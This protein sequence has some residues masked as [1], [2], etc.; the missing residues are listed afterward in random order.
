M[1]SR[2]KRSSWLLV[3]FV[4]GF[5][6][7][8]FFSRAIY[9]ALLPEVKVSKVTAGSV[10]LEQE[11]KEYTVASEDECRI[12]MP[13]EFMEN[14]I[15]IEEIPL[16]SGDSFKT[17]D[18]LICL[19]AYQG[20][21]LLDNAKKNLEK[22]ERAKTEW[23]NNYESQM[24]KL[25]AQL[26]DLE[27]K[28][29]FDEAFSVKSELS[30]MKSQKVYDDVYL[31]DLESTCE[32]YDAQVA[33]L[34]QLQENDWYI[35]APEDGI[36]LQELVKT[37]DRVSAGAVLLVYAPKGAEMKVLA[38]LE[39]NWE[40]SISSA[41]VQVSYADG[42]TGKWS[43]GGIEKTDSGETRL[44]LI[45]ED[46]FEQFGAISMIQCSIQSKYFD[47]IIPAKALIDDQLY[48][49][50]S[51]QGA[52]GKEEYYVEKIDYK[53]LAE[54]DDRLAIKGEV[55][56]GDLVIVQSTKALTDGGK[57]YYLPN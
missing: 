29:E 30:Y 28:E 40:D 33:Y 38:K 34:K 47:A 25:L 4:L 48:V 5:V 56:V 24:E 21:V 46:H 13:Y 41:N 12:Y 3:V 54:G 20:M 52:W 15:V 49:L 27:Q 31:S 57:V 10:G 32:T 55:N 18:P 6:I 36:M 17:G 42:S 14:A 1:S 7:L 8:T 9:A 11:I 2:K 45:P 43:Y 44:V 37:G 19:S 23:Q 35:L 22:A 16:K 51:E 50:R 39:M 53:I 26:R